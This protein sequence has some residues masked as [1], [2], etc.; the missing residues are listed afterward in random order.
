VRATMDDIL[1]LLKYREEKT[2]CASLKNLI[3]NNKHFAQGYQMPKS[4][5]ADE[6]SERETT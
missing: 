4:P 6:K 2:E 1:N 3:G 5:T